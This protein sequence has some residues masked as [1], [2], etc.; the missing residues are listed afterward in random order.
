MTKYTDKELM[1]EART[2]VKLAAS[3]AQMKAR[4]EGYSLLIDGATVTLVA[5]AVRTENITGDVSGGQYRFNV[6]VAI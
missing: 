2:S 4:C 3:G 6:N 5:H 1:R